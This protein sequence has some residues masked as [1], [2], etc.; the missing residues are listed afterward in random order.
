MDFD[1]LH[2]TVPYVT[3]GKLKSV[4][5]YPHGPDSDVTLAMPGK[6]ADQTSPPGGDFV[7]MVTD[8]KVK[9]RNHQFTHGDIFND[10]ELKITDGSYAELMGYDHIDL[11]DDFILAYK[12]VIEGSDPRFHVYPKFD[13]LAGLRAGPFLRGVQALAV[14]EHRRY[15]QH[16]AKFGGRYLPFRFSA[17][18]VERRWTAGQAIDKQKKGRLGVEMLEREF[19]LPFL[20]QE[21]MNP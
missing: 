17:G 15:A 4:K 19:G 3:G 18:I 1:E 8:S 14:A 11:A 13:Y 20:T 16:E 6:H 9:W 12:A 10:L 2:A 5:F 21:L 7:V